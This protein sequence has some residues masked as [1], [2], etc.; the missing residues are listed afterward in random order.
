MTD[1]AMTGAF[2]PEIATV[3][4]GFAGLIGRSPAAASSIVDFFI[5]FRLGQRLENVYSIGDQPT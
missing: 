5:W 4:A 3:A 2:A 1:P